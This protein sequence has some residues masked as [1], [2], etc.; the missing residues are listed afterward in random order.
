MEESSSEDEKYNEIILKENNNNNLEKIKNK[1]K[2]KNINI[3]IIKKDDEFDEFNE[4]NNFNLFS[5]KNINII[6]NA[7]D[8]LGIIKEPLNIL[9][10]DGSRSAYSLLVS[11]IILSNGFF[12]TGTKLPCSRISETK[13]FVVYPVDKSNGAR[14][15]RVLC[16]GPSVQAGS[17]FK[18]L[19]DGNFRVEDYDVIVVVGLNPNSDKGVLDFIAEKIKKGEDENLIVYG[20]NCLIN[21]VNMNWFKYHLRYK[22]YCKELLE[23][24]ASFDKESKKFVGWE[25]QDKDNL[26]YEQNKIDGLKGT[27][28]EMDYSNIHKDDI[29]KDGFGPSASEI[30]LKGLKNH[31]G[32]IATGV[33]LLEEIFLGKI[34]KNLPKLFKS[35][36]IKNKN[37]KDNKD[38]KDD[39]SLNNDAKKE[40]TL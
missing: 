17:D 6:N 27:A 21:G 29:P 39:K 14:I 23:K 20:D 8:D 2:N 26:N 24:I 4:F 40:K 5:E 3:K 35:K 38:V 25:G 34:R 9:V 18:K 13:S 15:T 12:G 19:C 28:G 1:D 10:L 36:E 32:K 7:N 22:T 37:N 30:A 33:L 11:D 31:Y 16:D